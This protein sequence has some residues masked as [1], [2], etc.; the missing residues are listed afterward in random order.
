VM[1]IVVGVVGGGRIGCVVE[2]VGAVDEGFG[3]AVVVVE[4]VDG[5]FGRAEFHAYAHADEEY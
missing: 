4:V 3:Y 1:P 2:V 5:G